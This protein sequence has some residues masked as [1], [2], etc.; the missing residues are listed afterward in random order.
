M[1][2]QVTVK[3]GINPDKINK[4]T[5]IW[6]RSETAPETRN[7]QLPISILMLIAA[8][9]MD[10]VIA[11]D[12]SISVKFIMAA[13]HKQIAQFMACP[14]YTGLGGSVRNTCFIR[15]FLNADS[16]ELDLAQGLTTCGG[17]SSINKTI[18]RMAPV[19]ASSDSGSDSIISGTSE[20]V[21]GLFFR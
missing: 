19:I 10:G 2:A 14:C 21:R 6:V 9:A 3:N 13:I 7:P 20:T 11:N 15:I 12:F 17:R 1:G 16:F 18:S 4:E 8:A 5:P